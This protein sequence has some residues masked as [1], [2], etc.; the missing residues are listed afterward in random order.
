MK[1]LQSRLYDLLC[2]IEEL[3]PETQRIM[4]RKNT[5]KNITLK[6]N[7]AFLNANLD[8]IKRQ[9]LNIIT[10]ENKDGM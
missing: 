6:S 9:A 8:S 1:N 7:L 3:E 10:K 5:F 2:S 4:K